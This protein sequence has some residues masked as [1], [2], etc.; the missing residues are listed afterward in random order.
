MQTKKVIKY[1]I[2]I[3]ILI[4]LNLIGN[5][6][7]QAIT[8]TVSSDVNSIDNSKYPGI[9]S[10]IKSLQ[11]E[12]PN[13]KFKILYTG[14]SWDEVIA[15]EYVGH[16]NSPKNL[17]TSTHTGEWLCSICGS[18]AYDNGSW[19]CASE[20]AI[21][22]M[23]DPRN[24]I[25]NSD[26]FQFLEL[27]YTECDYNSIYSMVK[28]TFL[29]NESYINTII[30]AGKDNNVSPFYIVALILQEQGS[31]GSSTI[32]GTY[33]GYEGYYNIFNINATGNGS[34]TIIRNALAYA[35]SRE[36]NTIEKAIEGGVEKI[37][38]SY[39]ARG[40]NTLYFQKFDVENSD[41]NLYWHQYQ[42]N[43]LAAQNEGVKMR[44][45]FENI[46]AFE[47]AY[48]FIIPVYE[49]MP[50][51]ICPMPNKDITANPVS[52]DIV[53]V[54]VSS[55]LILRDAPAGNYKSTLSAG[56]LVTR[57]EKATEKVNGTYWDKV[58]KSN[59]TTGYAA[60]ETYEKETQY[61]L[62]L[63][64]INEESNEAPQDSN[65]N[66]ENEA[67]DPNNQKETTQLTEIKTTEININNENNTITVV[68]GV[69][70]QSIID[71]TKNQITVKD[72]SGNLVGNTATPGTGYVINDKYKVVLLG[73]SNGD[74]KV[75]SADYI[76]IKNHIL[77]KS[78]LENENSKA[79]DVN[80]DGKI[81]S[82]D[83]IKI[84][85]Y[86]LGKDVFSVK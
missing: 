68:P 41:G 32:S 13:W 24:S 80:E 14:L 20:V 16:G 61:K 52:T 9:Q 10:M 4:G 6:Q 27:T 55:T 54:N 73:D 63:V 67:N 50:N 84:K 49:N 28:G 5:S 46:N 38:T 75:S 83:Y 25:N 31:K 76:N 2:L 71:T 22:Y 48:T 72:T 37:A 3:I 59:G 35:K 40:Q 82:A 8:Q 23:M 58:M 34:D 60:R 56:E 70:I 33:S 78:M 30:K 86:M 43:A 74:G 64:P 69:T 39:I 53:R 1:I 26:L 42:Q 62:Y 51:A 57:I 17:V 81:S 66:N 11:N 36:W 15:N 45:T 18:R 7:V 79:A 19:R 44:K 12:H 47:S 21:K 29:E 77:K 65:A 85:N